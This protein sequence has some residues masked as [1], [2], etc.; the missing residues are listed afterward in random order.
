MNRSFLA[1]LAFGLFATAAFAD[2]PAPVRAALTRAGIPADAVG[3]VVERADGGR[4]LVAHRAKVPM[5]PASALKLVTTYAALDLLGPA[6]TFKTDVLAS[7]TVQGGILDGDLI[8]R[9][10]GDPGLTYEK[11]WQLVLQLRSHGIREVDGDVILDRGFFAPVV[12]DPAAFDNDPRRAYN[13][14][15]DA[16]LV[17]FQAIE[18]H[19]V[20][21]G[22][23]VR[24]YAEPDLPNIE[25]QSA[26]AAAPGPCDSWRRDLR[27]EVID[28]GM[29]ATVVFTG[30]IPAACGERD[31]SLAVLPPAPFAET[32]LRWLWSTTGGKLKGK[33][34]EGATPADAKLVL[35]HESPPLANLVRDMN[36]FSNNVMAR[37]LFLALSTANGAPGESAASERV[38]LDWMRSRH[39]DAD[40]IVL[41]NGSGLSREARIT[42]AQFA[43]LLR[44]AWLAAV[45]P[46][47]ISSMPVY[48]V[49][50]TLRN[51][52][53]TGAVGEAHLKGGTLNGVH[54]M[55]GY[56]VDR[57]G[58]RWVVVMMV[59]DARA[60]AAQPA[61]DALVDW[62]HVQ[63]RKRGA[64]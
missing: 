19:F 33:V 3:L 52:R 55:A 8:L 45:M 54:S 62:V 20:P 58:A 31:W 22:G 28:H 25:I 1:L 56:V 32:L 44:D 37:N 51:R 29:L 48:G 5:T 6:F 41:D 16:L 34:R 18:F 27:Q 64:P 40:G 24:V 50:G 47:F 38:V 11:L 57:S 12:H 63:D 46:E 10:G 60:G 26:I 2:I 30:R 15:P 23:A 43:A 61:L 36:K 59:N 9:G 13:V 53:G 35:R 39:L 17:N 21:E 49:D 42:P 14:G 4:P 7:G